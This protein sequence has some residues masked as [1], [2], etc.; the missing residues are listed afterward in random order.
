[1]GLEPAMLPRNLKRS[2]Y[3]WAYI[4]EQLQ[5]L[6]HALSLHF[7]SAWYEHMP[8]AHHGSITKQSKSLL[9]QSNHN[10]KNKVT[11]PLCQDLTYLTKRSCVVLKSWYPT[12]L[13][14]RSCV[15]WN[16]D[17]S[18]AWIKGLAWPRNF[19]TLHAWW[20]G[21]AWPFKHYT[22]THCNVINIW[23]VQLWIHDVLVTIILS[24]ADSSQ[25]VRTAPSYSRLC[26]AINVMGGYQV[27]SIGNPSELLH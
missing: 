19:D 3:R 10:C 25:P 24:Y 13:T 21:P 15:S 1:M 2:L 12:C 4:D 17:I 16:S 26:P 18:H 22:C 5:W 9:K 23:T 20:G 14:R 8:P 11:R 27:E 7:R 6:L